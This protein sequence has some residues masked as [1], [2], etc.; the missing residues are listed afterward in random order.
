MPS[1]RG[2]NPSTE[3][4]WGGSEKCD[5][6]KCLSWPKFYCSTVPSQ[7]L[8]SLHDGRIQVSQ[9]NML[10]WIF[11]VSPLCLILFHSYEESKA[12]SCSPKSPGFGWHWVIFAPRSWCSAV[13]FRMRIPLLRHWCCC[14]C[15]VLLT[16]RTLSFPCSAIQTQQEGIRTITHPCKFSMWIPPEV[17]PTCDIPTSPRT[18]HQGLPYLSWFSKFSRFPLQDRPAFPQSFTK[19]T[20]EPSKDCAEFKVCFLNPALPPL[21]SWPWQG[22]NHF[23]YTALNIFHISSNDEPNWN[24]GSTEHLNIVLFIKWRWKANLPSP[25]SSQWQKNEPVSNYNWNYI[26]A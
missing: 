12:N 2:T 4:K 17:I 24:A 22:L 8:H 9:S 5:C 15:W 18:P 23:D 13:R 11:L 7:L 16:S 3:E 25:K 6:W 21:T 14:W 20:W 19:T 10:P 26:S 1:A